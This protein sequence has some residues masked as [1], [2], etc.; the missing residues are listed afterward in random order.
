MGVWDRAGV[1]LATPGSADRLAS[2]ARHVT[3]CATRP[4]L[5]MCVLLAPFSFELVRDLLV[6]QCCM[7]SKT[8][9]SKRTKNCFQHQLSLYAGQ[10]FCRMLQGEHFAIRS[11]YIKLPFVI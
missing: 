11:T 6:K 3:D 1:E 4:G 7:Y 5:S 8:C 2:V 9:V 10:K